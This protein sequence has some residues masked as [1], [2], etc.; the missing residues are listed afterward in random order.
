MPFKFTGAL[1]R[2]TINLAPGDEGTPP[3]QAEKAHS[4]R[5][6]THDRRSCLSLRIVVTGAT[7]C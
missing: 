6:G 5:E 1:E 4:R 2:L 3:P 7:T